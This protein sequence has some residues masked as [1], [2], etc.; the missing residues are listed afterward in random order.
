MCVRCQT[1]PVRGHAGIKKA[2]F[3]TFPSINYFYTAIK[4][5]NKKSAV[6]MPVKTKKQAISKQ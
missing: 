4:I 3:V 1:I 2:L 6:T 5:F